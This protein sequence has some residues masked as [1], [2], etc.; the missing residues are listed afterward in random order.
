MGLNNYTDADLASWQAEAE[1]IHAHRANL[2]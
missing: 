1:K 2:P